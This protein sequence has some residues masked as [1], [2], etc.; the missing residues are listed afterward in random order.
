[1]Q[2]N[3]SGIIMV[4]G[5]I[6][7]QLWENCEMCEPSMGLELSSLIA[8]PY[9]APSCQTCL[10][11]WLCSGAGDVTGLDAC[12][13]LRG[14]AAGDGAEPGRRAGGSC[15]RRSHLRTQPWQA[16]TWSHGAEV[17][18]KI[19]K[20]WR[21][22]LQLLQNRNIGFFPWESS[23]RLSMKCSFGLGVEK[24]SS[25]TSPFAELPKGS[26]AKPA[27]SSI[28]LYCIHDIKCQRKILSI[29]ERYL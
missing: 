1:M 24:K 29:I 12:G 9:Q 21:K 23:L 20:F 25:N 28:F 27:K 11:W 18:S 26:L 14:C 7:S 15:R 6:L 19:W 4:K 5:M 8:L 13:A 17:T 22:S 3:R 2:Y 16:Q 10:S